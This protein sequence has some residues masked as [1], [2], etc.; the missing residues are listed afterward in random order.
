MH[1]HWDMLAY[2]SANGDHRWARIDLSEG[3]ILEQIELY[4]VENGFK[5]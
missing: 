2:T 4:G 1:G 3:E 5:K